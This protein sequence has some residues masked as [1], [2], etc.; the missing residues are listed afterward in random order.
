MD[1]NWISTLYFETYVFLFLRSVELFAA[2]FCRQNL[3]FF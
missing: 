2:Q 1:L 3:I